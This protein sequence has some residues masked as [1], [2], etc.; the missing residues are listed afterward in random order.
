MVVRDWTGYACG[1]G[2]S[3]CRISLNIWLW[4]QRLDRTSCGLGPAVIQHARAYNRDLEIGITG[5]F[6]NRAFKLDVDNEGS[7]HTQSRLHGSLYE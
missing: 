6:A 4:L 3:F 1:Q 2:K 7:C 5:R